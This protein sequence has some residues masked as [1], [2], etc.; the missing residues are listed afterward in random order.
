[1][2][3]QRLREVIDWSEVTQPVR[4]KASTHIQAV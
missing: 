1:M 3:E 2:D 4:G